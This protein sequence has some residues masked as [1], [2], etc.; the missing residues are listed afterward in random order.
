MQKVV[1]QIRQVADSPLTVLVEGETGTYGS[2][3]CRNAGCSR[4]AASSW[5][6]WTYESSPPMSPSRKR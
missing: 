4:S 6:A 2:D 3:D 1:Q 5:S